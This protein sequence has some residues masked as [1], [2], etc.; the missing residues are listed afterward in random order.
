MS[1]FCYFC[2]FYS[3]YHNTVYFDHVSKALLIYID[4]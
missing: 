4:H 2:E 3:A 1:V